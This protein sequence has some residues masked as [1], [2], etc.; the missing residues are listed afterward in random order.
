LRLRS[1]RASTLLGVA[2][3]PQDLTPVLTSLGCDVRHAE[4]DALEVAPPYWRMDLNIEEDLIE[5]YVRIKG[6][7]SVPTAKLT[8]TIPAHEPSPLL[9]LKERIRESLVSAGLQEVINYSLTNQS[10]Q[11]LSGGGSGLRILNPLASDQE[12]LRLNLRHGLIRSLVVNQRNQENGVRLFE[13]GHI[14]VPRSE[15]LPDEREVLGV[16]LSGPREDLYWRRA[17]EDLDFFDAKGLAERL[18]AE[19]QV[20]ATFAPAK[21]PILHPGKTAAVLI[22]KAQ[23]GVIGE[24]HPKF[25]RTFDLL[26]RPAAYLELD[27]QSLLEA[28]LASGRR[29]QAIGR[30]PSVLRDL[31]IVVDRRLPAEQVAGL[32]RSTEMVT[33]VTLFDVYTG[34]NIAADKKSLAYRVVL[35]SPAK[36][37]TTEEADAL[38]E[39]LV[40][41]LTKEFGATLRG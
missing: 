6:F 36:T 17:E 29:Y 3:R 10:G 19:L 31:A 21:D 35:Q 25:A 23:A 38:Q 34:K 24:V 12:E 13:L 14:Y 20:K 1:Q 7:D 4:G 11:S 2:L 40:A 22:G 9:S 37:L 32:I 39:R 33:G 41:R 18:F 28:M 5:E 30:F 27:L 15:D 26:E 16:I 8:G